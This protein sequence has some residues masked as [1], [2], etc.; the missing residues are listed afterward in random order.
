MEE[1]GF[2]KNDNVR[3]S[4]IPKLGDGS[5]VFEAPLKNVLLDT[6]HCKKDLQILLDACHCK[7]DLQILFDCGQVSDARTIGIL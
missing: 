3:A 5:K 4:W 1:D 6:C 7:K 2:Q